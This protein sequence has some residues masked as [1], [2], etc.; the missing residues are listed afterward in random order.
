MSDDD[1][2]REHDTQTQGMA[3]SSSF[4]LDELRRRDA[5]KAEA[6]SYKLA[7]ESQNLATRAY[8]FTVANFVLAGVAVAVAVVNTPGNGVE[9]QWDARSVLPGGVGVVRHA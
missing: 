9:H 3:T 6:A 4:Y 2:I 5:A 1:V 7:V 8:R